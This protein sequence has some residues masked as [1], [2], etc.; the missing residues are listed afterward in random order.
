MKEKTK[1]EWA[2]DFQISRWLEFPRYCE[3]YFDGECEEECY[4][5]PVDYVVCIRR[6]YDNPKQLSPQVKD[7]GKPWDVYY[8]LCKK[9]IKLFL[10]RERA[11]A[12]WHNTK[13]PKN[14]RTK[15]TVKLIAVWKVTKAKL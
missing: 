10:K 3:G 14:A 8:G 15:M 13:Q 4:A 5:T 12:T 6:Q 2:K 7:S 1:E 11:N 9:H